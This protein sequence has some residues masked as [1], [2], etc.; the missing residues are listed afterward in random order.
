[1]EGMAEYLSI[2]PID[3]LTSMWLR[4]ASL[5]G[6]LPTV[7]EMTYDRGSSPTG[8]G[9]AL[10]AYVG[11]KWGDEAIGQILQAAVSSGVEAA[12]SEPWRHAR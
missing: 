8:S 10:L 9:H 11:E 1:M 12:S 3:P 6:H 7:E 4:D 2:G 5:E